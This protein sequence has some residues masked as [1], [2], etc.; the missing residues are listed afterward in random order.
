MEASLDEFRSRARRKELI[1]TSKTCSEAAF[2]LCLISSFD[3]VV[4]SRFAGRARSTRQRVSLIKRS[5]SRR[6][7]ES[8][9][10]KELRDWRYPTF[11]VE[12]SNRCC[13]PDGQYSSHILVHGFVILCMRCWLLDDRSLVG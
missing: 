10:F 5:K 11:S 3:E 4:V 13:L 1:C 6:E 12:S 9:C 7:S 8:P 2:R